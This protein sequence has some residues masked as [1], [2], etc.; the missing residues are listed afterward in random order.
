MSL[1]S[2]SPCTSTSSPSASCSRTL[3]AISRCMALLVAGLVELAGL[4]LAARLADL[5]GLRERADGG[6]RERRQL[7]QRGLLGARAGVRALALAERG[8]ELR[9]GGLHGGV[10][11]RAARCGAPAMAAWLAASSAAHGVA[12]LAQRRGQH[13]AA[14]RASAARRPARTAPPAS[15]FCS[16]ARSTGTCSSEQ[17]GAIHRRSPSRSAIG[18]SQSSAALR[19]VFQMLRPLTT[20]SDS[21]R[22]R[23]QLGEQRLDFAARVDGIEVQALR[24]AGSRPAQIVAQ[25]PK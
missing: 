4:E 1:R 20:P 8:V 2:A 21:T 6:G 22:V 9:D 25:R 17:D 16:L 10:V 19:S 7:E 13:A 12:A 11:A 18:S 3:R 5:R 14:R 23:G 24:P 15:S